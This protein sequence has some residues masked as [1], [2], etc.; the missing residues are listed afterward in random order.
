MFLLFIT[1][2]DILDQCLG[3]QYTYKIS[4]FIRFFIFF[5]LVHGVGTLLCIIRCFCLFIDVKMKNVQLCTYIT[6]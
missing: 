5:G 4:P 2:Y 6:L 3:I 1:L